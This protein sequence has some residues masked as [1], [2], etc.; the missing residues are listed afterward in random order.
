MSN[1]S[2]PRIVKK[3]HTVPMERRD[4]ISHFIADFNKNNI[5]LYHS[6]QVPLFLLLFFRKPF[7]SGI[8]LS[9]HLNHIPVP[10]LQLFR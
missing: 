3:K 5:N 1:R 2:V 6:L 7:L 4:N 10:S 9:H 8:S